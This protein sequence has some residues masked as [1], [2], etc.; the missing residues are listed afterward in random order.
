MDLDQLSARESIRDLVA[1]YNLYGDT[2]RL[3]EMA[4]LF[5][6]DGVLEHREA[7]SSTEHVGPDGV[8]AFVRAYAEQLGASGASTPV[9]HS[10]GTHVIDLIDADHA[11]GRAYVQMLGADGLEEWGHYRDQYRREAGSWRFARRRATT[12]GRA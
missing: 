12:V 7:G 9:F 2:G 6:P 1:R 10:V 11:D 4:G 8:L 3:E 5:A